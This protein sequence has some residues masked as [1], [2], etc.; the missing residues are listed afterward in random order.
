MADL[1]IVVVGSLNADL[2]VSTERMPNKGETVV[3]DDFNIHCG[4]KGANQAVAAARL[5]ARVAMVGAVGDDDFGRA[6]IANLNAA[7]VNTDSIHRVAD[8]PTGTAL[9]EVDAAGENRIVV[10]P[11]AN[12]LLTPGHIL[13]HKQLLESAR[14]ILLQLEIPMDAVSA[15]IEIGWASDAQVVLDPAPARGLPESWWEQIDFLTPNL[16]ELGMLLNRSFD[17]DDSIDAIGEEAKELVVKGVEH[18][19]VKL[20]PRGAVL[21]ADDNFHHWPGREIEVVDTTAA[22]DCFNGAFAVALAENRSVMEAGQFAVKA[23]ALSVT[24]A[25][26]Q[27][28]MPSRAMVESE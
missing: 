7:G 14:V 11:G 16:S 13:E 5:G 15:A 26:A 24:R 6:Q 21:V 3:G 18:V 20:G 4:G 19:M 22:G 12:G 10:V 8:A 17:E 2:V 9:I 23:A 1:D 28:A 25:G 27:D